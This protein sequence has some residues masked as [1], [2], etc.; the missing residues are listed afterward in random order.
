[1][2]FTALRALEITTVQEE[3]LFKPLGSLKVF[4]FFFLGAACSSRFSP[5]VSIKASTGLHQCMNDERV[6]SVLSHKQRC[7]RFCLL[8]IGPDSCLLSGQT[9]HKAILSLIDSD[10]LNY[11][12]KQESCLKRKKTKEKKTTSVKVSFKK[13]F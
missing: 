4:F 13:I 9:F 12:T 10:P 7:L 6:C 8:Q 1:M 3:R 5:A 2:I 11:S